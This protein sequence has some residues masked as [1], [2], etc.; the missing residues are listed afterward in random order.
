MKSPE[1]TYIEALHAFVLSTNDLLMSTAE[2][3]ISVGKKLA[4]LEMAHT[5][6]YTR[7][8][9]SEVAVEKRLTKL[10]DSGT[11]T[12]LVGLVKELKHKI[13]RMEK[14]SRVTNIVYET[15]NEQPQVIYDVAGLEACLDALEGKL[16]VNGE[17]WF[18][19]G[20]SILARVDALEKTPKLKLDERYLDEQ[21]MMRGYAPGA[22]Q[23]RK[24]VFG[25]VCL[26]PECLLD[27]YWVQS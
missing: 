12:Y 15:K 4:A 18:E 27:H 2:T 9:D 21:F 7:A 26:R 17:K 11:V 19:W 3:V 5:R 8:L 23:V 13:E 16:G 6:E 22:G 1:E 10:E 24:H 25:G 20:E 14:E